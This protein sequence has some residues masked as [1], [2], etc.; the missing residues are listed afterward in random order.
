MN[1]IIALAESFLAKIDTFGRTRVIGI[2]ATFRSLN[3]IGLVAMSQGDIIKHLC[4]GKSFLGPHIADFYRGIAP[5]TDM[6]EQDIVCCSYRL[7]DTG[8][9]TTGL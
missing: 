7:N 8:N 6:E 1:E 4:K 2:A 5:D 9:L 3:G